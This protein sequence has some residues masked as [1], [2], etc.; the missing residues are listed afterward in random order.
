MSK[1]IFLHLRMMAFIMALFMGNAMAAY[2]EPF[3][4][5]VKECV[6]HPEKCEEDEP[7]Q[8]LEKKTQD[9]SN[10]SESAVGVGATF[11]DFIKMIS[12][13]IFVIVLIYFLLRFINQKSRSY[14]QT[15]LIQHLGGAPL[16]GNRSV[17]LVKA[18][19]RILILGVGEDVQL[20]KEIDEKEEYD[21]FIE[22]YDDQLN[23]ML[24][25]KDLFSKGWQKWT[26]RSNAAKPSE[27][28]PFK[29]MIQSRLEEIRKEREHTFKKF[30]GKGNKQDE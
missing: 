12:A 29:E 17:Q 14:Q 1:K 15:K 26:S 11:F 9:E 22:H 7:N 28:A 20:L 4:H 30:N 18:G 5:N 6:E 3:D 23:Q 2:A 21:R 25:P 8:N 13:L 27:S 24:Q 19:N 10:T 16:G